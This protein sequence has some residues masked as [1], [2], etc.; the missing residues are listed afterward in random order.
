[1]R[2]NKDVPDDLK[3]M[4]L[5]E[6]MRFQKDFSELP[7]E[8]MKA[9]RMLQRYQ[10]I[11]ISELECSL[12]PS[13]SVYEKASAL[14]EQIKKLEVFSIAA[15]KKC[16]ELLEIVI[17]RSLVFV[18]KLGPFA[19]EPEFKELHQEFL[20]EM[21]EGQLAFLL[22]IESYFASEFA[23][24]FLEKVDLL[25]LIAFLEFAASHLY[26]VEYDLSKEADVQKL[27]LWKR[28]IQSASEK[29]YHIPIELCNALIEVYLQSRET[30]T[31]MKKAFEEK[32]EFIRMQK[33]SNPSPEFETMKYYLVNGRKRHDHATNLDLI[34]LSLKQ[35]VDRFLSHATSKEMMQSERGTSPEIELFRVFRRNIEAV[36]LVRREF[37][38]SNYFCIDFFQPFS[39]GLVK[40]IL[41]AHENLVRAQFSM[42]DS[43]ITRRQKKKAAAITNPAAFTPPKED[44]AQA[45]SSKEKKE[46]VDPKPE[47][48]K[49][50]PFDQFFLTLTGL[51]PSVVAN[52]FALFSHKEMHILQRVYHQFL[53]MTSEELLQERIIAELEEGRK[54]S[55]QNQVLVSE[56][57]HAIHMTTE[58]ALTQLY[59]HEN[60]GQQIQAHNLF[61]LGNILFDQNPTIK[62]C[63]ESIR[64]TNFTARYPHSSPE[65]IYKKVLCDQEIPSIDLLSTVQTLFQDVTGTVHTE[66]QKRLGLALPN[67]DVL[68]LAQSERKREKISHEI[69]KDLLQAREQI[70]AVLI[71]LKN[72]SS[73]N[74]EITVMLQD[75]EEHIKRINGSLQLLNDHATQRNYLL[76]VHQTTSAM[77]HAFEL[78]SYAYSCKIGFPLQTHNLG[79][80]VSLL[81]LREE[82]ILSEKDVEILHKFNTKKGIDYPLVS[83]TE[84]NAACK[85]NHSLWEAFQISFN[86]FSYG[87]GFVDAKRHADLNKKYGILVED[88]RAGVSVLKKLIQAFK[89]NK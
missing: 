8:M 12:D 58:L 13:M 56:C 87:E 65:G 44:K 9:F 5:K 4:A 57:L 85:Y 59:T 43:S 22:D 49:D 81:H 7:T 61:Y 77:Q 30:Y 80:Y 73:D 37:A 62:G 28:I 69:S 24:D 48:V 78:I 19:E 89:T 41:H 76:F 60:K 39:Q 20:Y 82:K 88:V 26:F 42:W 68:R 17:R 3:E 66:V 32:Y 16:K 70:S 64:L 63:L 36:L 21:G 1:V 33:R 38:Q 40:L 45:S 31:K 50:S 25:N 6:V 2:T 72:A 53:Y 46:S 35:T 23:S 29:K 51:S 54:E 55:H 10:E 79:S 71:E 34:R 14:V 83:L 52:D 74:D 18:P 47:I 86:A 27:D 84:H 15:N 67:L 75:C 11:S